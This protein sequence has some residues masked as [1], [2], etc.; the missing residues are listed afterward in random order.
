MVEKI[1]NQ[2][3]RWHG[4]LSRSGLALTLALFICPA[5]PAWAQFVPSVP[6]PGGESNTAQLTPRVDQLEAQIRSLT[7]QVEQYEFRIR[8]LE[9]QLR[10]MQ[11]DTEFR[12]QELGGGRSGAERPMASAPPPAPTGP[13]FQTP[14]RGPS[15]QPETYGG[16]QPL[17]PPDRSFPSAASEPLN[18]SPSGRFGP[19]EPP[20][21]L[22]GG[23]S[24]DVA[25][26]VPG[27]PQT[28]YDVAY[29]FVLQR[30]FEAAESA[31]GDFLRRY[32]D[33]RLAANAQYWVGESRYS[34]GRYRE[35]ADAYLGSY[36]R[37]KSGD[38]APDS[39]LKL[40]MSLQQLG[41]KDA[42]CASFAEFAKQFPNVSGAMRDRVRVEQKGAGC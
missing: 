8:Q 12:F 20:P 29:A 17:A 22:A 11:Q 18:I 38:K 30:D 41:Q 34:Q 14:P 5:A 31:F 42:A 10:R 1:I 33:H 13:R 6:V 21:P 19:S 32:P 9:E 7:G 36:R 40:A 39:L 2:A 28:S 24:A 27:D 25:L 4:R 16:M 26:A 35:A 3:A 15:G 23:N 37:S